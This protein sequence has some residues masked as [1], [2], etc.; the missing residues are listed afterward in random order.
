LRLIVRPQA[1]AQTAVFFY[2]NLKVCQIKI[3]HKENNK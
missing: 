3:Y 1:A 2:L